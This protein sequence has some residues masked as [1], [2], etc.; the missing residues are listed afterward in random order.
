MILSN[1]DLKLTPSHQTDLG[2]FHE[3]VLK[4]SF[5][6]NVVCVHICE[7]GAGSICVFFS[8]KKKNPKQLTFCQLF[9]AEYETD[10]SFSFDN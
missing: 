7:L 8:E 6:G 1:E 4:L 2:G 10:M 5:N 3:I 9:K